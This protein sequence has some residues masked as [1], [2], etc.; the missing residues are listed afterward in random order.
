MATD[1]TKNLGNWESE[2]NYV[3]QAMESAMYNSAHADDTLVLVGPARKPKDPAQ[4]LKAVGVL[5]NFSIQQGK[6]I[7]PHSAIGSA[8]TFFQSSKVQVSG[9]IGRLFVN[10][11]NLYRVLYNNAFNDDGTYKLKDSKPLPHAGENSKFLANLDSSLFHIPFGLGV[12][13]R[14]KAKNTLGG[15]YIELVVIP[16]WGS[17]INAGSPT[18]VENTS[19]M[20]DR[21]RALSLG[22]I[23]K[24]SKAAG[25]TNTMNSITAGEDSALQTR[26]NS[27]LTAK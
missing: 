18:I 17:Q 5:Q 21:V 24:D 13:Y 3:E 7:V 22:E 12:V 16:T 9:N 1:V 2:D 14:D 26:L 19:F 6:Q 15:I 8:R 27:I 25:I 4:D 10:G 11:K 20:A 23:A